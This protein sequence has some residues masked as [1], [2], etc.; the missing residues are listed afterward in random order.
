MKP[1]GSTRRLENPLDA[2]MAQ[3]IN[4]R[5]KIARNR[6]AKALVQSL[7]DLG[8]QLG[9]ALVEREAEGPITADEGTISYWEN[10]DRVTARVPKVY[11]DVAKHLDAE[12]TNAL[13]S[14]LRKL[15]APLRMGATSMNPAFLVVNPLRDATTAWFQEGLIPFSPEWIAG[16][17]AAFGRNETWHEAARAGIFM[18]GMSD[19]ARAGISASRLRGHGMPL[20]VPVANVGDALLWL[21][22]AIAEVNER[23]EQGTRVAVWLH[24]KDLP[25]WEHKLRTRDATVDFAKAGTVMQMLN[26]VKPFIN[27]GV[28]SG[29]NMAK[30]IKNNPWEALLRAA[31]FVLASVLAFVW[32]KQFETNSMIPDYEYANNWVFQLGEGQETDGKQFPIYLKIPKGDI[33]RAAT[34]IPEAIM[35]AAW[36][37]DDR[38]VLEHFLVAGQTMLGAL[39]PIEGTASDL[40]LPVASTGIELALNKNLYTGRD[41]VPQYEQGRPK[42]YQYDERT[43]A[44]AIALGSMFKVSPRMIAHAIRGFGAG[45]GEFYLETLP[46]MALRALGYNPVAPG[47]VER[48]SLTA[49]ERISELPIAYRFVGTRRNEAQRQAYKSLDKELAVARRELYK[50]DEFKRFGMGVNP[51][52]DTYTVGGQEIEVSTEQRIAILRAYTPLLRSAIDELGAQDYYQAASESE[53][54]RMI[55]TLRTKLQNNARAHILEGEILWADEDMPRL[56]QALREYREYEQLPMYLGL[57]EEQEALVRMANARVTAIR[58]ANPAI[59]TA[60]ARLMAAQENPDGVRLAL[61]A[62]KLRNPARQAYWVAHPYLSV[63]FGNLTIGDLEEIGVAA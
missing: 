23:M 5:V 27:V 34:A 26:Q 48:G 41:I 4:T 18:S 11:A 17:A 44:V 56:V 62:S 55:E 42:E 33:V 45:G 38:S 29:A 21:P 22:R 43:P 37:Q 52:S 19:T 54:R 7:E 12:P 1:E 36:A 31:P 24:L 20:G 15:A 58:R 51:P 28:Q 39:S 32:N 60:R 3:V 46:G 9:K 13:L 50:A 53:K 2:W 49:A 8:T 25:E 40:A 59:T 16:W 61:I 47:G 10:G 35:Q 14:I 30:L 57:T 63:Y 6:A